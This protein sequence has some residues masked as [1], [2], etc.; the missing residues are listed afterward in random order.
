MKKKQKIIAGVCAAVC[1]GGL[2][3]GI[4]SATI[5]KKKTGKNWLMS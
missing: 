2:A 4:F 5:R 1:I 3:R